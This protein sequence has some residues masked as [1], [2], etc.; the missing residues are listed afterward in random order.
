MP[1]L[2]VIREQ[3]TYKGWTVLGQVDLDS[4]VDAHVDTAASFEDNFKAVK[5]KRREAEKLPETFKVDC[6]TVSL[7][8]F[9]ASIEDQLQRLADALTLSLRNSVL[10]NFKAIDTFLEDSMDKLGRRPRTINDISEVWN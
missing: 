4:F 3:E 6:I 9:K 7:F 10:S 2:T 5:A 8:P 1:P